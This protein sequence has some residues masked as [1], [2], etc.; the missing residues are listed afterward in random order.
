MIDSINVLLVPQLIIRVS[1]F[2]LSCYSPKRGHQ[3]FIRWGFRPYPY[4]YLIINSASNIATVIISKTNSILSLVVSRSFGFLL[5]WWPPLLFDKSIL[6]LLKRSVNP[7][8]EL[9]LYFICFLFPYSVLFSYKDC[10]KGLM[11]WKVIAN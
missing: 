2:L 7:F 3:N 5:I 1:F 11:T 9:I 10:L 4:K 8:S 6:L